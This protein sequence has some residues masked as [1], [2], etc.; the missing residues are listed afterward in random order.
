[1]L[2]ISS[3][4]CSKDNNGNDDDNAN[5]NR[6]WKFSLFPTSYNDNGNNDKN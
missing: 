2:V 5:N 3:D 1:M 4:K 6:F